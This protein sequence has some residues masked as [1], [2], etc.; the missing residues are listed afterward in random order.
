MTRAV[1]CA[2]AAEKFVM[3][4]PEQKFCPSNVHTQIH[5]MIFRKF[6]MQS[7]TWCRCM[8]LKVCSYCRQL[9]SPLKKYR[10]MTIAALKV[11]ILLRRYAI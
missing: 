3:V 1:R 6:A 4:S 5:T 8:N 11:S 7:K 9:P 10:P 2:L